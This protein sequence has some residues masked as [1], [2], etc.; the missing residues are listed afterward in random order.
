MTP[1]LVIAFIHK[2][3]IG[4]INEQAIIA[5]NKAA[6]D[7]IIAPRNPPSCFYISCFTV[8]V[9]SLI[10]RPNFFSDS[11]I[12]IISS[13]F[14]ISKVNHLSALTAPRPL[15]FLSNLSNTEE[16]ALVAK[17]GKTSLAKGTARSNN[18]F[19]PNLPIILPNV[20]PKNPFDGIILGN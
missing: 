14:K 6:I 17:L 10:N 5:I 8:L 20:L 3:T 16:F 4:Y 15:T 12:L 11:T 18:A 13:S 7:D 1:F 19:L 2:E 9:A